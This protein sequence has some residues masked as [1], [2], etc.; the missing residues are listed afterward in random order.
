MEKIEKQWGIGY[1]IRC[2]RKWLFDDKIHHFSI[3]EFYNI[4]IRKIV[5]HI[6]KRCLQ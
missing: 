1:P 2:G 5:M 6:S 3:Y 4:E